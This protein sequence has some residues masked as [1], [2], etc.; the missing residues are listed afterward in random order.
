MHSTCTRIS[1]QTKRRQQRQQ[2]KRLGQALPANG[3][4]RKRKETKRK[5]RTEK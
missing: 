1:R 3:H 2:E 5:Q 4:Q